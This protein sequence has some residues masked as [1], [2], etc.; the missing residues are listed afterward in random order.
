MKTVPII[1][2]IDNIYWQT[3]PYNCN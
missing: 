1:K 2:A 3:N